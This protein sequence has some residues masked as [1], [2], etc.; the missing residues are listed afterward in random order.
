V[1]DRSLNS[2]KFREETGFV[3][4]SWDELVAFMYTDYRKR[5]NN[6]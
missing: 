3:P 6:E 2:T 5:Y 1:M 4:P